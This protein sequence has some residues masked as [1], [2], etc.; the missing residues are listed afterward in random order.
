MGDGLVRARVVKF[1][2]IIRR[3][4]LRM[5]RQ[6]LECWSVHEVQGKKCLQVQVFVVVLYW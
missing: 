1:Y 5:R 4:L 6:R 3:L 2:F